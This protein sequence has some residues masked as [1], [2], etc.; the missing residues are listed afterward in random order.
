MNKKEKEIYEKACK[1]YDKAFSTYVS[2]NKYLELDEK[3]WNF[4][5][6][7]QMERSIKEI[8]QHLKNGDKVRCIYMATQ[9]RGYH[10]FYIITKNEK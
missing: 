10:D 4:T 1:I 2:P 7:G 6:M 8:E 3:G 9:I 5:P